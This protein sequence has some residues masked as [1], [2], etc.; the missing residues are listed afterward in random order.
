ME[1]ALL[2]ARP[3]SLLYLFYKDKKAIKTLYVAS[4]QQLSVPHTDLHNSR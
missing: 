4:P 3:S 1:L 2:P